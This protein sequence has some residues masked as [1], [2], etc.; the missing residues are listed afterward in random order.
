MPTP[1]TPRQRELVASN[2]GLAEKISH[3]YLQRAPGLEIDEVVAVAYQGLIDA[4]LRFDPSRGVPFGGFA[5]QIIHFAIQMW[6]R[7]ED[8]LQR[9][10]RTDY[11]KMLESGY[12]ERGGISPSLVERTGL[13]MK[14]MVTVVRAVAAKPTSSEHLVEAEAVLAHPDVDVESSVV[15][16]AIQGSVATVYQSLPGVQQII[17]AMVYFQGLELRQ[18]AENLGTSVSFVRQS[19]SEAVSLLHE[20]MVRQ[21]RMP[22]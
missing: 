21:A 20:E 5:R 16:S 7:D 9:N 8:Y 2:K 3:D 19:H 1:L 14:R 6:Q 17:V 15:V 12:T 11:K 13:T 10:I 18:V 22:D 4:A